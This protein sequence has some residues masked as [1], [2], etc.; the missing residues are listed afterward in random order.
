MEPD[1]SLHLFTKHRQSEQSPHQE[2]LQ[3]KRGLQFSPFLTHAKTSAETPVPTV[4]AIVPEPA[5]DSPAHSPILQAQPIP[6]QDTHQVTAINIDNEQKDQLAEPTVQHEQAAIAEQDTNPVATINTTSEAADEPQLLSHEQAKIAKLPTSHI[7]IVTKDLRQ[8]HIARQET[9]RIPTTQLGPIQAEHQHYARLFRAIAPGG[10]LTPWKAALL[11]LLLGIIVLRVLTSGSTQFLGAQGWSYALYGDTNNTAT[12]AAFQNYLR[13]HALPLPTV[14]GTSSATT[15]K[16]IGQTIDQII[17]KMTLD[18]KIGQM[19]MV[20]SA[21]SSVTLDMSTM[22]DQYH[23]GAF[24][25]SN[26]NQNMSSQS[27]LKS[28]TQQLQQGSQGIP[29]IIATDQEGGTVNRLSDIYGQQESAASIGTTNNPQYA[30]AAGTQDAQDLAAGGIN[31][32]LAPVVDVDNLDTSM[33]HEEARAFGSDPA[34][35]TKMAGA[36][37]QGLQQSGK[38]VGVIK[39][40]PG[41]GDVAGNAHTDVTT[42][43]RSR[44][45]LAAIDWAPYRSLIQ[46]GKVSCVM[47]T[48]DIVPSIDT[49]PSS[50][51][52]KII[53][54]VLRNELHFNGVVITDSLT[55][56]GITN[57]YT[58]GQASAMAVEA[59]NDML[60]GA[61]D[62]TS[63]AIM[64]DGIKQ[65]ITTGAITQARLD[66][67]I[68]RILLLKYQMGLLSFPK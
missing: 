65:A 19:M 56:Q 28:L 59:G 48:H 42:L 12:T 26:S 33:I 5:A 21:G 30:K 31:M 49:L 46:Q 47:V 2:K 25:L 8:E 13:N 35:V 62:A 37:L 38:V 29:L 17:S 67:S 60:M 53:Q 10:Q 45:D 64:T 23:V 4:I 36:Y 57:L 18:Q 68:H 44:A 63:L 16:T 24:I 7:D 61:T 3:K 51:S 43:T 15:T 14:Q 58:L 34:T 22:L 39:H 52:S 9:R 1:A 41:L 66:A 20:E 32:N 40:F 27:Q 6:E 54:G 11:M 50:L 55:M